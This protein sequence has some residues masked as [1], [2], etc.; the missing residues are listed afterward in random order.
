MENGLDYFQSSLEYEYYS[1]NPNILECHDWCMQKSGLPCNCI[2]GLL[3]SYAGYVLQF[4]YEVPEK[5]SVKIELLLDRGILYPSVAVERKG[6]MQKITAIYN[7]G[8]ETF[9]WNTWCNQSDENKV[10]YRFREYDSLET[11]S[12]QL[13]DHQIKWPIR[14]ANANYWREFW[15][16]FLS[17]LRVTEYKRANRVFMLMAIL[18]TVEDILERFMECLRS[19]HDMA[20][21]IGQFIA[22][23]FELLT[24]LKG[25]S[26]VPSFLAKFSQKFKAVTGIP[27]AEFIE[28][29]TTP[30]ES[31]WIGEALYSQYER[32]IS[33][34]RDKHSVIWRL[35]K[36]LDRSVCSTC[37]GHY[38]KKLSSIVS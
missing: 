38:E 25:V 35:A 17:A 19:D 31:R 27:I 24:G 32:N 11:L 21:Y 8:K 1:K 34:C 18:M 37:E 4:C 16:Y 20:G 12:K 36:E 30:L 3:L 15:K 7:S 14:F 26:Y 23:Y 2:T 5:S 28:S 13:S 9:L 10:Y 33:M 22:D 6:K 29:M